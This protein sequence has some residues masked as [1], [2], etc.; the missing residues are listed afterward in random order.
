M[1]NYLNLV[2][3]N[4]ERVN[5]GEETIEVKELTAWEFLPLARFLL[6]GLTSDFLISC[7]YFSIEQLDCCIQNGI[8]LTPF[9]EVFYRVHL[10]EENQKDRNEGGEEKDFF[11]EIM[12]LVLGFSELWGVH[13]IELMKIY[14]VRQLLEM[15]SLLN[16]KEKQDTG[17]APKGAKKSIDKFGCEIVEWEEEV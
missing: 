11:R 7:G 2:E 17:E 14:S 4:T 10:G 16:E 5:V 9:F 1:K 12:R 15:A 8:D 3:L 6:D 13:P